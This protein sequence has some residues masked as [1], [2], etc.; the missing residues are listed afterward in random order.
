MS[1]NI[2]TKSANKRTIWLPKS[3]I[4]DILTHTISDL[5]KSAKDRLFRAFALAMT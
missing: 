5:L 1:A 2:G 3:D 4:L